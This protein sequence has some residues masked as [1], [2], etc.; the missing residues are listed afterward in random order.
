M[1]QNSY[2]A[3]R[4][5]AAWIDLSG[6]GKI[7]ATGDDRVR[8]LHAMC[9]NNVENLQP[10]T[11]CYAFF[12]TAQGRILADLNLFYLPDYLLL[13]T[14][15]DARQRV[16][17]HLD[18]FIIADDVTLHDFTEATSTINLEGPAA[19]AILSELGGSPARIPCSIVEWDQAQIA[20]WTYTGGPGYSLFIPAEEKQEFIE[21]LTSRG[22][23]QATLETADVV[24]LEYG[25]PRYGVDFTDA[26]IPQ[27]TQQMQAVHFSK[28]CYLGQEIVE[29]VRSR[30]HVNR[31]L[32]SLA[33][34][35]ET[36]PARGMKVEADGKETGEITSA[37]V[38]PSTGKAIA[39]G[40][41]RAE[42]MESSLSVG[43]APA[44][45]ITRRARTEG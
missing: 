11:G 25:R 38:S 32:V 2:R 29:R 31:V 41:I 24:R 19:E 37:V 23:P 35:S 34:D 14:E 17:E 18:K 16:L 26:N 3:L 1:D 36:P 10:G 15:P 5:R 42:A 28:G 6:R 4:E 27:E 7:R 20:H 22:V 43:G 12:L 33:I 39:F 9:T 30:G 21:K 44:T 45:V 40:I 13:D 8:L